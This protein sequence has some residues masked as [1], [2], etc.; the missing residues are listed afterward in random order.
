M[1]V[2]NSRVPLQQQ[3]QQQPRFGMPNNNQMSQLNERPG[4]S[5]QQPSRQQW[6]TAQY[7]HR[8]MGPGNVGGIMKQRPP[9]FAVPQ[10][11]PQPSIPQRSS[12]VTRKLTA[13]LL[14]V[15]PDNGKEIGQLLS[16]Y[17][18]DQNLSKLSSILFGILH[19]E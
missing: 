6:L 10:R 19:G 3:P 1:N 2:I 16:E 18:C 4:L 14:E 17:P 7:Q 12:A 8:T 15:F 9:P 11:L 5:N 13:E